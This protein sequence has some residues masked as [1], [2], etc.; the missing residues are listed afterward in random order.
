MVATEL[1][2]TMVAISAFKERHNRTFD[3]PSA[4]VDID[5][6]ELVLVVLKDD[7]TNMMVKIAPNIYRK[8]ITTNLKRRPI[9]CVW[10]QKMLYGLLCSAMLFYR[11]LRGKLEADGFINNPCNPCL[12]NKMTEKG[13]H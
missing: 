2:F 3:I 9:L 1:V 6:D 11:K 12:A 13:N 8:L 5:L 4:F 7:M 10:L